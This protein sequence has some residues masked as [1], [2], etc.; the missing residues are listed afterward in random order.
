V[1]G[2]AIRARN[3]PAGGLEILIT[4][5]AEAALEHERPAAGVAA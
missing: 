1:H 3:V 5:P 2:G 4:L